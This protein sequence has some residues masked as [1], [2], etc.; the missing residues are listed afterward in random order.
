MAFRIVNLIEIGVVGH[1]LG[2]LLEE[3]DRATRPW[4]RNP[5]PEDQLDV[6]LAKLKSQT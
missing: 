6:H 5:G 2:S 1:G 3:N 4:R